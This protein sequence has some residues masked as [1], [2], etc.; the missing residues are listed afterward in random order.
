MKSQFRCLLLA[1][2]CAVALISLAPGSYAQSSRPDREIAIDDDPLQQPLPPGI[3]VRA[4]IHT[5]RVVEPSHLGTCTVTSG[6]GDLVDWYDPATW[7]LSGTLLWKLSESTIPNSLNKTQARNAVTDAFATWNDAYVNC[8]SGDN[9]PA[10]FQLF[11][12]GGTTTVKNARLDGTNAILWKKLRA[13]VV[14][15]TYVWYDSATASVVEVDTVFNNGHP[16]AIFT[17][18]G[19]CSTEFD[20]YDL[21]NIATHEFGHW[22]GLSDIYAAVDLTMYLF[23]AGGELKKRSL[24]TGDKYGVDCIYHGICQ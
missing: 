2:C 5:P 3:R 7:R 11:S 16:W 12:D 8:S 1:A 19:D 13:G 6:S 18:N 15:E 21:Q 17:D 24:G 14:G 22:I 20:A 23:G 9:C 10:A 4:F